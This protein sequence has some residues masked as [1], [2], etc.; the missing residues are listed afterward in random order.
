MIYNGELER[1][2]LIEARQ[3][4]ILAQ[5]KA[6]RRDIEGGMTD[7]EASDKMKVIMRKACESLPLPDKGFCEGLLSRHYGY[8]GDYMFPEANRN[9]LLTLV[10]FIYMDGIRMM[11]DHIRDLIGEWDE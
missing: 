11:C 2:R 5:M 3:E 9:Q 10:T 8:M 4:D 1:I 7:T 6:L